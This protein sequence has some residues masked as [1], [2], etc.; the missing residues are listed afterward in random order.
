MLKIL[1]R[2]VLACVRF[3]GCVSCTIEQ[4]Q[5]EPG[6]LTHTFNPSTWDAVPLCGVK[7][8]H[9]EFQDSGA[10]SEA[11]SQKQTKLTLAFSLGELYITRL[12]C[13]A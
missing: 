12:L 4:Q 2:R 5:E 6:M 3:W 10:T 1:S 11:L 8:L 7:G 9:D 13:F